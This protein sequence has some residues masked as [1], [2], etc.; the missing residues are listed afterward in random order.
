MHKISFS[1]I[2]GVGLGS[3][4]LQSMS[5]GQMSHYTALQCSTEGY[6]WLMYIINKN[7]GTALKSTFMMQLYILYQLYDNEYELKKY[8]NTMNDLI[9]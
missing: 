1:I 2:Q 7:S 3:S 9:N 5:L 4:W 8:M 6:H